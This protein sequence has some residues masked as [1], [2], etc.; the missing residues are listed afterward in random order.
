MS[1]EI[2]LMHH[3]HL[4]IGYTDRQE[5]IARLQAWYLKNAV[6]YAGSEKQKDR[7]KD[8]LYKYVVDGFWS[9]E[10]YIKKYGDSGKQKLIELIKD[11]KIELNACYVHLA[12]LLDEGHLNESVSYA[13]KFAKEYDLPLNVAVVTD[14]NGV[15]WA[16][17]DALHEAGVKYLFSNLNAHHG[18]NPLRKPLH[19][20]YWETQKGNKLLVWSGFNYQTGNLC[21]IVPEYVPEG[22]PNIKG[23][24][25]PRIGEEMDLSVAEKK[26]NKQLE[27]LRKSGYAYHF[28]PLFS[29]GFSTDNGPLTETHCAFIEEWNAKHG[30]KIHIQTSTVEEFFEYLKSNVSDIPTYRGDWSDWW[31]DGAIST[32]SS[33]KLFR[34]AE[35]NKRVVEMLDPNKDIISKERLDKITNDLILFSEHTW[36]D[37]HSVWGPEDLIVLQTDARKYKLAVDADIAASTALDEV[38][39]HYG[40]TGLSSPQPFHYKVIN[41]LDQPK[42]CTAKLNL[43]YWDNQFFAEGLRVT[44][45]SGKVYMSQLSL[46]LRKSYVNIDI[47]LAPKEIR[48]LKLEPLPSHPQAFDADTLSGVFENA[49][50][51]LKWDARRGIT[52][53]SSKANGRE[54]LDTSG[55]ML[56]APVYQVFEDIPNIRT[57][58]NFRISDKHKSEVSKGRLLSF[59]LMEQGDV[60]TTLKA[61]YQIDGAKR[62]EVF[63]KLFTGRPQIEI[64]V[65][66]AKDM[67]INPEGMYTAFPFMNNDWKWYM[68]KPG[69]LVMPGRDQLPG[70]CYDYYAVNQGA[71]LSGAGGGIALTCLDA[72]MLTIGGLKLWDFTES[73]EPKGHIY[74]WLCNNKWE[75][76]FKAECGG[77]YEM[78]YV[79]EYSDEF[80]NL[81]KAASALKIN[82]YRPLTIRVE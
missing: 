18:F 11:K 65:H 2:F 68:D 79:L 72:P 26:L 37:S 9:V 3:S 57:P 82:S 28:L 30:D 10:Q 48:E 21:G 42:K 67:V 76:N 38:L 64:K 61:E 29:S 59:G 17:A 14:V 16:L 75:T 80:N 22:S 60:L 71:I 13:S 66:M 12:E 25:M 50:Y 6:E 52:S 45:K 47:E 23:T 20:F 34:N 46:P 19:P 54:L 32:P 81:D 31:T 36:G 1:F 4:D 69:A 24:P 8:N 15:P 43:E 41:P 53:L 73:I 35:R 33:V 63:Y 27:D 56:G 40:E 55:E 44:D 62:Y 39:E 70:A 51:R 74:S 7:N 58:W 5:K 77:F 49:W 78:R